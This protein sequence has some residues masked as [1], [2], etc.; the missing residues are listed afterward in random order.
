M[1]QSR[2][3]TEVLQ[4]LRPVAMQ[5]ADTITILSA[6]LEKKLT[7][8]LAIERDLASVVG[9][10][11]ALKQMSPEDRIALA[12]AI[13][14]IHYVCSAS[15]WDRKEFLEDLRIACATENKNESVNA[16]VFV[17]NADAILNIKKVRASVKALSIM[18]DQDQLYLACRVFTDIRPIFDED[19]DSSFL[20]SLILHTLKLTVRVDGKQKNLYISTD[21][22]DLQKLK[23]EIDRALSKATSIKQQITNSTGANFGSALDMADE[24]N[25]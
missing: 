9:E 15:N 2:I 8:S 12:D 4:R 21:S 23:I 6:E 13:L 25:L 1:A 7:L 22:D 16:D 20:A 14:G 18:T 11:A 10:S 3:L 5:T 17:A 24:D 19:I